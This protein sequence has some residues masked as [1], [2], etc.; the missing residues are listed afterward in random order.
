MLFLGMFLSV[1]TCL[2]HDVYI[3]IIIII[4]IIISQVI[5]Q[6]LCTCALLQW[7]ADLAI[8]PALLSVGVCKLN[9][10]EM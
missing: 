10:M 5:V 2:F 4:I 8:R 9:W 3:I 7:G 1:F 6:Y